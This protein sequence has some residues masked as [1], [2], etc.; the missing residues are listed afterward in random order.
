MGEKDP[1]QVLGFDHVD[2]SVNDIKRSTDFYQ[3]VLGH[4]GFS[5]VQPEEY[6]GWSNGI[7]NIAIRE[8]N[9]KSDFDRYKAGLHHLALRVKSR[10]DVDRF[11]DFLRRES[12]TILD[13]PA[14]YPEYGPD[15]Y[16]VFFADPDGLK[17]EVVHFPWGYW[18]KVQ[19]E[20]ADTRPRTPSGRV[21][22]K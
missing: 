21:P 22:K 15:Y 5:R 4:L 1:I 18:R 6:I 7:V 2:L 3:R 8:A 11:H 14:E 10:G 12:V 16:A 17:L 13:P 19:T 9:A 20:G